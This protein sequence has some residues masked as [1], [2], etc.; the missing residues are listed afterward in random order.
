[1]IREK[2]NQLIETI[3]QKNPSQEI[4]E[5]K[6]EYQKISG[7]IF[8]D[9]KSYETRMSSFLEWFTFD[10]PLN[11]SIKTPLQKYMDG[12][13]ESLSEEDRGLCENISR[14]INGLF[15]LKKVKPDLVVVLELLDDKKYQV[16]EK[17]GEIL[18]NKGDVFEARLV[19][20][21]DQFFFSDNFCYH[22]KET[23]G[24][25]KAKIKELRANEKTDY[26]TLEQKEKEL[27]EVQKKH[28]KVISKRNKLKMKL[29]KASAENKINKINQELNQYESLNNELAQQVESLENSLR[30]LKQKTIQIGHRDNRFQ[31]I[32][33]L[34]YMNLKWERSRQIDVRDIYQD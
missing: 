24:F 33:R 1:M 4:F 32:R 16:K 5:A 7:K 26:K 12:Q 18:F 6:E 2:L 25:I 34:S 23:T 14:S 20:F 9:D 27:K 13:W 3:T 17:Q 10:R 30:D 11:N 28:G 19:I 8:E 29:S 31:L 21:G 15:V 22:P